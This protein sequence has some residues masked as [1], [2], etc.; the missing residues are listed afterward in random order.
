M[1]PLIVEYLKTHSFQNLEDEHG[2]IAR[3]SADGT[4]FSLNY[5]SILSKNGDPVAEQCR[6]MVIRPTQINQ[7]TLSDTWKMTPVGEIEVIAWPMCRFYNFGDAACADV[8][9]NDPGLCVWEKVDGTCIILYWDDVKCRWHAATR[10]VCEADLPIFK[11]HIEIGDMTF[12]DLFFTTLWKMLAQAGAY[13]PAAAPTPYLVVEN[14]TTSLDKEVTYVFELVSPYNQIV[15]NYGQPSIYLIAARHT[16]TG[17]EISIDLLDIPYVKR[18]KT[19]PLK[20]PASVGAFVNTLDP[21]QFEGAVV[22]DS[23]FRRVKIKSMAYVLAHKSKDTITASPRNAIEAIIC[24]KIDDIIP[25]V[26]K[27]VGE[28]MLKMQCAYAKYC[29]SVDD[30][31][32]RYKAEAAGSRKFFAEQVLLSRDWQ[33]PYFNLWEGR[34]NSTREWLKK[35]CETGKLSIASLD[36]ILSKLVL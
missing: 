11:G 34:A 5:D 16:K 18:P 6:G 32:A 29:K 19:W 17:V 25:L 7:S 24:E 31:F 9:W 33:T 4:K 1:K 28:K 10:A 36:T 22:C 27:E 3:P 30:A 21:S 26:P 2:V 15:V 20:D 13:V 12:S 8:N 35:S 23:Q 14:F